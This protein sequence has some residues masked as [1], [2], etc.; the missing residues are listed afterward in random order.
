MIPYL[1]LAELQNTALAAILTFSDRVI[2]PA[3][4]VVPRLWDVSALEDQSIAGVI[5]WV[6]GSVPFLVAVLWLVITVIAAPRLASAPP[7]GRDEQLAPQK[8]DR[9][10]PAAPTH[11]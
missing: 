9:E 1:V 10:H 8:A 5:M 3:Y 11:R 6:P 4:E 2:Y 7:P